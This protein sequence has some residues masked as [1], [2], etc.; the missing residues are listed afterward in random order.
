MRRWRFQR[1]SQ[2]QSLF[3]CSLFLPYEYIRRYG[4][5]GQA[6]SQHDF[7]SRRLHVLRF[8]EQPSGSSWSTKYSRTIDTSGLAHSCDVPQ[9]TGDFSTLISFC[10]LRVDC[11]CIHRLTR[12]E[13]PVALV[14][15]PT[16]ISGSESPPP[17]IPH[18]HHVP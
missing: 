4:D 13:D 14:P 17:L 11:M 15:C 10:S 8:K 3:P 12:S 9:W 16:K 18:L 7:H 1:G 6:L 2:M 5:F